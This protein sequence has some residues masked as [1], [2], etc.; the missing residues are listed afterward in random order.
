MSCNVRW[1]LQE[2]MPIPEVAWL[3]KKQIAASAFVAQTKSSGACCFCFAFGTDVCHK[4][5]H[6][7]TRFL[8]GCSAESSLN[9]GPVLKEIVGS[10]VLDHSASRIQGYVSLGIGMTYWHILLSD[11][12]SCG[13]LVSISVDW[14]TENT[15][16]M[17]VVVGRHDLFNLCHTEWSSQ[18]WQSDANIFS[19]IKDSIRPLQLR[20]VFRTRSTIMLTSHWRVF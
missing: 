3:L 9:L 14:T 4:H 11:I 7:H 17:Q 1:V 8:S 6:D 15:W 10:L 16:L 2:R 13:F 5:G 12:H 18:P 19:E 20:H